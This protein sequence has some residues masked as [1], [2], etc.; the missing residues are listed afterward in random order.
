VNPAATGPERMRVT[1]T[2][3]AGVEARRHPAA[4]RRNATREAAAASS[5]ARGRRFAKGT[6]LAFTAPDCIVGAPLCP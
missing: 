2:E 4:R 6:G 5:A 1:V 3:A